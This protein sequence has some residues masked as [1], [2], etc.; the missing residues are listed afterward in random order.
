MRWVIR[1]PQRA[2]YPASVHKHQPPDHP[3]VLGW[4][5]VLMTGKR[6]G[7]A[8]EQEGDSERR[9]QRYTMQFPPP[10]FWLPPS[11]GSPRPHFPPPG[12]W[13]NQRILP[14]PQPRSSH[15]RG[16]SPLPQAQNELTS[17]SKPHS[18]VRRQ[19]SLPPA[20]AG[21]PSLEFFFLTFT[22]QPSPSLSK[23]KLPGESRTQVSDPAGELPE[24]A[25]VP[26]WGGRREPEAGQKPRP[27]G[28]QELLDQ[29][30]THVVED[31]SPA[32]HGDALEHRQDGEQD[33]VKVGDAEVGSGPVLPALSVALTQPSWGFLATR[34]VTYRICICREKEQAGLSRKHRALHPCGDCGPQRPHHGRRGSGT[35]ETASCHPCTCPASILNR[36]LAPTHP[37]I[38][39][40]KNSWSTSPSPQK[41]PITMKTC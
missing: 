32:L 3:T 36:Q 30:S 38:H 25:C 31:V 39:P 26:S 41:L 29:D 19:G 10:G 21:P 6:V 20:V 27:K 12:P 2:L 34:E 37:Q 24:G 35:R 7:R 28:A 40:L 1:K 17:F 9:K 15:S 4:T 16:S 18:H 14:A 5:R 23:Q 22:T 8:G 33:V 11:P 13:H